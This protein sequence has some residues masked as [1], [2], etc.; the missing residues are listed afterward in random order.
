MKERDQ[1]LLKKIREMNKS[2]YREYEI[3]G[4]EFLEGM[5]D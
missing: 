3:K 4:F 1:E 2:L 5:E